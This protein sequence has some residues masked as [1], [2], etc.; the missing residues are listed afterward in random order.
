MEAIIEINNIKKTYQTGAISCE[1]LKG[2]SLTVRK[3]GFISLVGPSGSGKTTALNLMGCLDAPTEGKI[4]LENIDIT[5]LTSSS[6]TEI[7]RKKIGFIFQ[8]F[9]LLQALT[10][11]EN[12]ELPLLFDDVGVMERRKSVES[13]M[14]IVGIKEVAN[15]RVTD[16]SGGQQQRTAIARALIK[17]PLFVLADEPTGN[18]DSENGEA[19]MEL[20]QGIN[21]SQGV[22][23]IIATHDPVVMAYADEVIRFHDGKIAV[24]SS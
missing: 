21:A 4:F 23:F 9:N 12:I 19:I 17:K 8:S 13:L 10:V 11:Y 6:L 22:T 3:G 15:H 24:A 20:M 16:I 5:R 2:I 7:R 14:E 1:A 18:L